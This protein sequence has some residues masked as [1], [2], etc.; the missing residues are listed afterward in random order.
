MLRCAAPAPPLQDVV[1][2]TIEGGNVV[3]EMTPDGMMLFFRA[4]GRD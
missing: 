1:R 2:D 3:L 4:A